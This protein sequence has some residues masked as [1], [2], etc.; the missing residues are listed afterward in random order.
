MAVRLRPYQPT[1]LAALVA[2]DRACFPRGI[3]YSRRVLQEFLGAE[4]AHS[5]LA[6]DEG[7]VIGFIVTE[8]QVAQAH[9]ITLDVLPA[10]QRRGVGTLLLKAAEQQLT[11]RG[12]ESITLE[13]A[14][15]NEPAIAFW[16]EH[17]YVPYGKANDYYAPGVDACLMHKHFGQ[18]KECYPT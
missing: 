17:G 14:T 3:A 13:T 9:I 18:T 1:D 7:Q 16:K 12:I 15:N 11:R 4:D 6:E 2:I 5:I 8:A 10:Y